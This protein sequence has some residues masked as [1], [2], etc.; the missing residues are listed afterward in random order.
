MDNSMTE[1]EE[2]ILLKFIDPKEVGDKKEIELFFRF[3]N[4]G[5]NKKLDKDLL[6]KIIKNWKTSIKHFLFDLD[7]GPIDRVLRLIRKDT[8]LR[9]LE[10]NGNLSQQIILDIGCGRQAH[11]AWKLTKKITS[12]IGIDKSIPEINYKNITLIQSKGEE[13][14]KHIKERTC[15]AITALAVIEHVDTP[16][17]LIQKCYNALQENGVLIVTTPPPVAE[18]L[19]K[20]VSKIGL[21]NKSEIDEHKNYFDKQRLVGLFEGAGFSNTRY[22]KFLFGGNSVC[23]GKRL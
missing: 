9:I 16:E 17:D 14:D 5:Y 20:L 18:P 3:L 6:L 1:Y 19:L 22:T 7:F 4:I 13:L 8:V 12:Y 15:T 23:T 11:L 2:N 10:E 21:I